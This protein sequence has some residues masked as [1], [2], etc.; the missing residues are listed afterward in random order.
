MRYIKTLLFALMFAIGRPMDYAAVGNNLAVYT[1]EQ[2]DSIVAVE[3]KQA[4]KAE[5]ARQVDTELIDLKIDK[6]ANEKL[7]VYISEQNNSLAKHDYSMGG[8]ITVLVAIMGIGVPL[9]LNREYEKRAEYEWKKKTKTLKKIQ[10]DTEKI[11]SAIVH[12]EETAKASV[13]HAEFS[14]RLARALSN[15]NAGVQLSVLTEIIND[16]KDEVFVSDAYFSR[17][18]RYIDMGKR[19]KAISDYTLAI[20]KN[21]NYSPAFNSRGISY[22]KM[23]EYKEAIKDFTKA[24]NLNPDYYLA[25]INRG[26]SHYKIGEY[27]E[28]IT[29][30]TEATRLNPDL[31]N[32]YYYRGLSKVK[33]REY[34]EAILDYTK[35]INLYPEYARAYFERCK[36][37]QEVKRLDEA[38]E[39]AKK[40]S[41]IAKRHGRTD[42][43][44]DFEKKIKEIE[45]EMKGHF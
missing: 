45:E 32:A 15:K 7:G 3:V 42:L 19:E 8:I 20:M 44:A 25:Y 23:G 41:E 43:I 1:R 26:I 37:Q 35:V 18:I 39:D 36:A 2:I 21:P 31:F 5:V 33:K 16:Y 14:V 30:Y 11:R 28:A 27:D 4:V 13:R 6:A 29:D 10:K 12:S 40:G 22:H 17:A 38:F 34:D 9:F 24:I